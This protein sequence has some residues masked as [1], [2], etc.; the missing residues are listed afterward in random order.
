MRFE[1]KPALGSNADLI[2]VDPKL[3]RA[4]RWT[5]CDND[6]AFGRGFE[7]LKDSIAFV[8]GNVQAV[9]LRPSMR[10]PDG[11]LQ[12]YELV[13]GYKRW[14]ACAELGLPLLSIVADL[15]DHELLV[16]FAAEHSSKIESSPW[17]FGAACAR[18]LGQGLYPSMRRMA[19]ALHVSIRDVH[20]A[21]RLNDLPL[22]VRQV[23]HRVNMTWS[24]S[25]RLLE[26]YQKDPTGTLRAAVA[27]KRLDD[28]SPLHAFR[29][30]F[31]DGAPA[32][33]MNAPT[34]EHLPH[35]KM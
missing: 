22:P 6:F 2:H 16:H 7:S 25:N 19:E 17:R 12:N 14:R 15:S 4:C 1:L 28:V 29:K 30:A 3:L 32:G 35:P 24:V 8:G 9:L 11:C 13:F 27:A 34:D 18:A 21:K 33:L 20:V 31:P 23:F 10:V 5:D 26:R